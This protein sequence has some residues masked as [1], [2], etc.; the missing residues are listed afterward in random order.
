MTHARSAGITASAPAARGRPAPSP[1]RNV[2]SNWGAFVFSAVASFFVA[3]FVVHSLGDATY[4]AWVLL[5]SMVGYLGLLDLGVR[6]AI[7]RYV[8]RLHAAREHEEAGQ[9]A[10]AGLFLFGISSAIAILAGI[11]LAFSLEH[12]FDIPRHLLPEAR[13]AVVL[14]ASTIAVALMTGVYGGV[15]TAMQRF[16]LVSL[17]ELC[18]ELARITAVVLTLRAGMGLVALAAI[19]LCVGL[20]RFG[21]SFTLSRKLY[22][23]LSVI[24]GRWTRSHIRQILGF[25]LASTALHSAAVVVLLLDALVVGAFLPVSMVTFFS[26]A[27]TLAHYGRVVVDGVTH[28]VPPRV[29]AQE[30]AGDMAGARRTALVGGK[31]ATLVHLPIVATFLLRGDTFIGLWMGPEY[32]DLSGQ[33]LMI[34]SLAYWF[35]AGRQTLVT[36]LMGLNRHRVLI[37]PAWAEAVMNAVLSI[38]FVRQFGVVGV[39]W[40]TTIPFLLTTIIF[41]PVLFSRTLGISLGEIWSEY[42]LRPSVAI[43]PFAAFSYVIDLWWQP[44]SMLLFFGQVA[45]T[46]M[47]GLPAMWYVGLS[48]DERSGVIDRM[49]VR[50]RLS[51]LARR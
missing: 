8:A 27:G 50:M 33:V 12:F 21:V 46:L 1:I 31:V 11:G 51:V 2:L 41:Y 17:C 15:V 3:P 16:D 9:F 43:L 22:P 18:L 6:G 7:M 40:G 28:T 48:A 49:P 29:S 20:A 25:S 32:A 36:T 23:E 10:S 45:T 5:G 34:L 19:Q 37:K 47:L 24:A 38:L 42:W 44:H 39:A 26:I 30:G 35:I 4:G 14:S 13:I